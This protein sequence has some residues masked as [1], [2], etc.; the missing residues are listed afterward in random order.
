MGTSDEILER[1]RQDP[2]RAQALRVELPCSFSGEAYE[3]VWTDLSARIAP[4]L[5]WRTA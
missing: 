1:L 5:G 2:K 4:A 3:Q